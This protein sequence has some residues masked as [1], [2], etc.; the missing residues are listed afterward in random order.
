VHFT[1]DEVDFFDIKGGMEAVFQALGI[2]G[3][4]LD[5]AV[6]SA[7]Y[8]RREASA[9]IVL[10]PKTLGFVGEMDPSVC[11]GFDVKEKVFM[12]ELSLDDLVEAYKGLKVFK[13]LPRYPPVMR[14]IAI[15]VS[16]SIPAG[17][18]LHVINEQGG[19]IIENVFIFDVYQG[20]QIERGSKSL[21]LRV[22][23]RSSEKTL[24]DE[25]VNAIHQR[26]VNDILSRF[27]G[28]LRE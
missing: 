17:Q 18:I 14:D 25:E 7:P 9:R 10:G 22:I 16:E 1:R 21:A 24:E 6:E 12:F 3:Y 15:I 5:Q 26:I 8:L 27:N 20:G 2:S 23:Y 11:E 4:S 13:P 19:D 28:R